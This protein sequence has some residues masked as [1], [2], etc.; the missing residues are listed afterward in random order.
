MKQGVRTIVFC[1]VR[2]SRSKGLPRSVAEQIGN[3]IRKMC[4][5]VM[6]TLRQE[7]SAEGRTDILQQVMAYRGGYSQEVPSFA[8]LT[9]VGL[10]VGIFRSGPP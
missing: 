2:L 5:L 8:F 3:Q 6:K 10:L 1:K 7:L 4:E 9:P